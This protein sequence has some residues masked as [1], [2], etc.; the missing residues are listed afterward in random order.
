MTSTTSPYPVTA[1]SAESIA[2]KTGSV[3][4]QSGSNKP[5]LGPDPTTPGRRQILGVPLLT[6][7]YVPTTN[8]VVWGISAQYAYLVVREEA[9][10]ELDRSVFFTSDRVAV[11]AIV[12]LGFGF[13][14][15]ASL[16]KIS[17]S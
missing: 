11:R 17:T 1:R 4:E 7:P 15:P 2:A 5:L 16:V 6:S 10:V 8:N 9:E 14:H 13:P 3:K 12:R